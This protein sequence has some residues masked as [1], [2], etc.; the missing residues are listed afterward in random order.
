MEEAAEAAAKEERL[1]GAATL[2]A[3][4]R[5]EV[6]V[7]AVQDALRRAAAVLKEVRSQ[8][9]ASFTFTLRRADNSPM[10]LSRVAERTDE[11]VVQQKTPGS[12]LELFPEPR[13]PI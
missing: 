4:V 11:F 12:A 9:P 2:A 3:S 8:E 7:A 5:M 6:Q 13:R 1:E 10:G